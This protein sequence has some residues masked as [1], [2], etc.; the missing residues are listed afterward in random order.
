MTCTR[1]SLMPNVM[2]NILL[3]IFISWKSVCWVTALRA[4]YTWLLSLDGTLYKS[5]W[6]LDIM[7]LLVNFVIKDCGLPKTKYAKHR[8]RWA[9]SLIII[10][11]EAIVALMISLTQYANEKFMYLI[12]FSVCYYLFSFLIF[13]VSIIFLS[14]FLYQKMLLSHFLFKYLGFYEEFGIWNYFKVQE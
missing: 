14:I 9:I 5:K 12:E 7:Y 4:L 3:V 8:M 2:C 13:V 10:V 1:D 6:C 11:Q